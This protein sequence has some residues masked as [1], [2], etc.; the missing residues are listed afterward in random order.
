VADCR[1]DNGAQ[2]SIH[3][4]VVRHCRWGDGNRGQDHRTNNF[5]IEHGFF[6]FLP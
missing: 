1:A 4:T 2:G 6:L 5:R 3:T